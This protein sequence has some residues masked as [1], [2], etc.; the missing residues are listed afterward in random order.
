MQ[1]RGIQTGLVMKRNTSKQV[2]TSC[3]SKWRLRNPIHDRRLS[4]KDVEIKMKLRLG[5]VQS[6][7]QTI[8]NLVLRRQTLRSNVIIVK[9]GTVRLVLK[10]YKFVTVFIGIIQQRLSVASESFL[11]KMP[12]SDITKKPPPICGRTKKPL[13]LHGTYCLLW[14]MASSLI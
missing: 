7:S 5:I 3:S 2:R 11:T 4:P 12:E 1:S 10:C 14:K 9:I 13:L 6:T 8:E